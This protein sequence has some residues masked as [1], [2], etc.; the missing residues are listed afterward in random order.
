MEYYLGKYPEMKE[1]DYEALGNI[2]FFSTNAFTNA[3]FVSQTFTDGTNCDLTQKNRFFLNFL[4]FISG[5]SLILFILDILKFDIIVLI[6]LVIIYLKLKNHHL[7]LIQ[8]L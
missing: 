4:F 5:L 2:S 3:P 8:L 1:N 7:A 6:L